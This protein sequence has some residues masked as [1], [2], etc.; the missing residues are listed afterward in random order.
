[1]TS[2]EVQELFVLTILRVFASQQCQVIA[3]AIV[4]ALIQHGLIGC[5]FAFVEEEFALRE[6]IDAI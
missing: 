5:V 3:S 1:M 2:A 4:L 6:V